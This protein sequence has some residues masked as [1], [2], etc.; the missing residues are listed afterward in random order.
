LPPG[1]PARERR[2]N[3][4]SPR[5]ARDCAN[6]SVSSVTPRT[7]SRRIDR[8]FAVEP[9]REPPDV[10][11]R[12]PLHV[13]DLRDGASIETGVAVAVEAPAHAEGLHL[14]DRFHLVDSAVA[15]DT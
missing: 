15:G 14:G 2:G 4:G 8:P 7:V 9:R 5:A 12:R 1:T 13:G 6:M 11:G 10:P 3:R